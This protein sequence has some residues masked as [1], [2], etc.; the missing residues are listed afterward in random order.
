MKLIAGLGNPGQKYAGTRH[1]AGFRVVDAIVARHRLEWESAPVDALMARW[2]ARD[3]L[4][5]KPLTFMNLSGYAVGELQRY[6]KIELADLLVIVD[7]AQLKLGRL[8]ARPSGSAGGHNG[9]KSLIEQLGTEQFA[10][11][12]IGVGRGDD[13]RDL[14]DHVLATFEPHERPVLDDAVARA[15]D[16]VEVFITDG[17]GAMMNRFNRREDTEAEKET[18]NDAGKEQKQEDGS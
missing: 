1:N 13:R 2:R 5:V 11:L 14:A 6:F 15:A 4:L 10:R 3:S 7:E 8:R 16:A 12:R 9:L 18:E 17:I